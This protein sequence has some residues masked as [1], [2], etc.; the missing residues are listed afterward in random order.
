MRSQACLDAGHA[1]KREARL[2]WML[3]ISKMEGG[4]LS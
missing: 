4:L 1:D 2:V 3:A